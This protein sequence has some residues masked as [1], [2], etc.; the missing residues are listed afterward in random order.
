M[1]AHQLISDMRD[2]IDIIV[3]KKNLINFDAQTLDQAGAE[4]VLAP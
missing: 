4:K 3:E 1:S 2:L